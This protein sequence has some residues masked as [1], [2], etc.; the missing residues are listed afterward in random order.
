MGLADRSFRLAETQ[1]IDNIWSELK[2]PEGMPASRHSAIVAPI[3]IGSEAIGAVMI[4]KLHANAYG[5]ADRFMLEVVAHQLGSALD[6][7][8]RLEIVQRVSER[9]LDA[10]SADDVLDALA[11]GVGKMTRMDC[12]VYRLSKDKTRVIHK[13]R[14]GVVQL[15]H[16]RLATGQGLTDELIRNNRLIEVPDVRSDKRVNPELVDTYKSITGIPLALE[17][18]VVG[19]LYLKG[20]RLLTVNEKTFVTHL[21]N[22]AGIVIQKRALLEDIEAKQT[23]YEA[24]LNNMQQCVTEKDRDFKIIFANEAFCRSVNS[25]IDELRGMNDYELYDRDLA[26]KYRSDDQWVFDHR[27]TMTTEEKHRRPK[28]EL[29]WVKVVKSPIIDHATGEITGVHVVFWDITEE[30]TNRQRYESLVEQ[31]PDG[32]VTHKRGVIQFAN[33]AAVRLLGYDSEELL[34]GR[35]FH[36]FVH[37]DDRALAVSQLD[38]LLEANGLESV[39]EIR[40]LRTTSGTAKVVHVEASSQRGLM[41]GEVQVVLHDLTGVHRV[42]DEMHHRVKRVLNILQLQLEAYKNHDSPHVVEALQNRVMALSLAHGILYEDRSRGTISMQR[43][44]NEL[45]AALQDAYSDMTSDIQV[46]LDIADVHLPEKSGTYCGLVISELV[47]NSLLHAF[48]ADKCV[49]N[50]RIWVKLSQTG[51]DVRFEVVDNGSGCDPV[52]LENISSMGIGL[53]RD[54][55]KIDLRGNIYFVCAPGFKAVGEFPLD[56]GDESDA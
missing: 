12:V 16:P 2:C 40:L 26:A 52:A 6:R 4:D 8:A 3:C 43:F 49:N 47:A 17:D 21:A 7:T 20:Q 31:S 45:I 48:G 54:L 34:R 5:G 56:Q 18:N 32:I 46:E 33:P 19:V 23:H 15:P 30:K 1:V 9:I 35:H 22:L 29:T 28:G 37:S 44:L 14:T 10:A 11:I 36:D 39:K 38:K 42:L 25:T 53:V 50:A 13:C 51:N 24:L 55:V 27:A 41:D